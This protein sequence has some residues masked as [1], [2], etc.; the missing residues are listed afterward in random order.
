MRSILFCLAIAA[1]LAAVPSPAVSADQAI[2]S[3]LSVHLFLE[4]HGT[5]SPDVLKIKNFFTWNFHGHSDGQEIGRFAGYLISVRFT[6]DRE[7]F[8]K[9]RQATLMLR[10]RKTRRTL[11]TRVLSDIYVGTDGETFRPVL[12]TGRDCGQFEIVLAGNGN[13]ISRQLDL[14]CGE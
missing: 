7:I 9:G 4:R 12:I 2:P 5:L 6:S 3:G 14:Q 1:T 13:R 11:E 8:A 10:D